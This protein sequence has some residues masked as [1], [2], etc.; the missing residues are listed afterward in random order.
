MINMVWSLSTCVCLL[1]AT[2]NFPKTF[3][4][5]VNSQCPDK[6]SMPAS[7]CEHTCSSD[8]NCGPGQICC[9]GSCPREFDP[10]KYYNTCFVPNICDQGLCLHGSKCVWGPGTP[11][12]GYTCVCLPG[13]LGKNCEKEVNECENS[14]CKNGGTCV[15][16]END[17]T[18]C[19]PPTYGGNM[20]EKE[21]VC[22]DHSPCS[23]KLCPRYPKARC[24][25]KAVF[26]LENG[27]DVTDHC[28]GELP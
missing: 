23:D 14:P 21:N 1:L 10:P 13:W 18:C 26:V 28:F 22:K 4:E 6:A 19:C 27:T 9:P 2:S 7:P 8:E 3:S 17:F 20:C 24:Q 5:T 11:E 15:D 16:L 25:L 12:N